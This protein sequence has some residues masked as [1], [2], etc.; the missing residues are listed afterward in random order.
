MTLIDLVPSTTYFLTVKSHPDTEPTIAWAPG[1]RDPSPAASCTTAASPVGAPSS[2]ARAGELSTGSVELS[3]VY[4]GPAAA[5]FELGLLSVASAAAEQGWSSA[6]ASTWDWSGSKVGVNAPERRAIVRDLEPG[7]VHFVRVR[8][9]A[10]AGAAGAA[11]AVSDAVPFRTAGDG[12]VYS[13]MHR[14][15]EHVYAAGVGPRAA[16][17]CY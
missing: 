12:M 1:W 5:G 11:A 2:L 9:A 13:S 3:W 14:I 17:D 7:M 10:A 15:S 16:W 4:T 8:A 6:S